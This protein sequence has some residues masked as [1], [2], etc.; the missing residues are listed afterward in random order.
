MDSNQAE[1]D[2]QGRIVYMVLPEESHETF[3]SNPPEFEATGPLDPRWFTPQATML[4]WVRVYPRT[5]GQWEL[6]DCILQLEPAYMHLVLR[7][8][9][10]Q[11]PARA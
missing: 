11:I 3:W 6:Q 8:V 2:T 5:V 10:P 7:W 9:S 1:P 4:Y